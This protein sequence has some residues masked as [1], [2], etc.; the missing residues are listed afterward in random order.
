MGFEKEILQEGS[1]PE[2]QR[3]QSVTVHCTLS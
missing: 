2:V 1:G 3:N